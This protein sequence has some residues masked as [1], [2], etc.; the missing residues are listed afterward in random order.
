[1][2]INIRFFIHSVSNTALR[3]PLNPVSSHNS[4]NVIRAIWRMRIQRGIPCKTETIIHN[5]KLDKT[6][7]EGGGILAN[8]ENTVDKK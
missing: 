5:V 3:P 1:M 2:V 6:K 4:L 8:V 7:R